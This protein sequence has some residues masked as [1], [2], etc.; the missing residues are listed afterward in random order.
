MPS[1]VKRAR[2]A[3]QATEYVYPDHLREAADALP[4]T[5]GVYTF[6]GQD[7]LLPL[8]IGKSVNVRSRVME[9]LRTPEEA[10]LLRQ[11]RRVSCVAMAGDVGARLLEARLIKHQR[12]LYNRLLRKVPRQFSL[13][14]YR[15]EVSVVHSAE[16]DLTAT[17]L[18]FGL[19]SSVRSA[20][21]SLRRIADEHRLCY[22]LLGLER[23]APGRPCFRAMIRRCAGACCGGETLAEHEERLRMALAR[24]EV[25]AWPF[26]GRVALEEKGQALR[27]FH[28]L[29][30]W[31]YL[32]STATL[33]AAR[34]LQAPV[35]EFDRDAYRIIRTAIASGAFEVTPLAGG[36]GDR[37]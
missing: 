17:P 18:L 22:A 4:R 30:A 11:A 23:L 7:G 16:Y 33:A 36:G 19:Y 2:R 34:R 3:A 8:Y 20:H 29:E 24:L 37:A 10:A 35:G 1:S 6:H 9:H 25:A 5:P 27:Q 32:G 31:H 15:G 28:V 14:L 21:E 12:P 13:R 26:F